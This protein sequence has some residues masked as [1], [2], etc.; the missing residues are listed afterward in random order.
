MK[1]IVWSWFLWAMRLLPN[2]GAGNVP[3]PDTRDDSARLVSTRPHALCVCVC[4]RSL[5]EFYRLSGGRGPK[6]TEDQS[7]KPR[8]PR[9]RLGSRSTSHG[10]RV[11][12]WRTAGTGIDA[13][14]VMG[15]RAHEPWNAAGL[16]GRERRIPL[17]NPTAVCSLSCARA[18]P[19]AA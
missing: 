1:K 6:P 5:E 18:P 16:T 12:A 3:V 14:H 17:P 7:G 4:A 2:C 15:S 13:N 10:R 19:F 11:R 8:A 9:A